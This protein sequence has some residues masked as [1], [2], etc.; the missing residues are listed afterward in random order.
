M[1]DF[2][3]MR[4]VKTLLSCVKKYSEINSH[5]EMSYRSYETPQLYGV[6]DKYGA[7]SPMYAD[8]SAVYNSDKIAAYDMEK[9]AAYTG[10]S[11][12]GKLDFTAPATDKS[13]HKYRAYGSTE[14]GAA[15]HGAAEQGAGEHGG[16]GYSTGGEGT[17][18][19]TGIRLP[20]DTTSEKT[21][22][23]QRSGLDSKNYSP[24]KRTAGNLASDCKC[25]YIVLV[26][27]E[28]SESYISYI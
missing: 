14:H 1:N 12:N 22:N 25:T 11:S 10:L 8:K 2:V 6:S 27:S 18:H 16:V 21:A 17:E 9:C 15:E 7:F 4:D 13:A 3:Y 23:K 20:C 24:Q 28:D 26:L 19:S 5:L